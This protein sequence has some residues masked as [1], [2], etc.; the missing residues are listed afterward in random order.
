MA[1]GAVVPQPAK[2]APRSFAMGK[3]AL[4]L[5]VA[6]AVAVIGAIQLL[7]IH[8]GEWAGSFASAPLAPT[9]KLGVPNASDTIGVDGVALYDV[10]K[11]SAC[12]GYNPV[13]CS[14]SRQFSSTKVCKG[15]ACARCGDWNY[16]HES[17]YPR[18][19]RSDT[20]RWSA[21]AQTISKLGIG[22]QRQVWTGPDE[23]ECCRYKYKF[24][25]WSLGDS[26]RPRPG[27]SQSATWVWGDWG[28]CRSAGSY[29]VQTRTSQKQADERC[30]GS[31]GRAE[32]QSRQCGVDCE[33]HYEDWSSCT[34]TCDD[35]STQTSKLV[36]TRQSIGTGQKC[37]TTTLKTRKCST[38]PCPIDCKYSCESLT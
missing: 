29:G 35:G 24:G 23:G 15:G 25:D 11:G 6:A 17:D 3:T 12:S 22:G 28:E 32:T 31:P 33:S 9:T 2:T 18:P 27:A 37:P 5:F 34:S 8:P 19:V 21:G 1:Y 36:I 26:C 30:G 14:G 10:Q 16:P 13:V 7:E 20:C 4:A 38:T